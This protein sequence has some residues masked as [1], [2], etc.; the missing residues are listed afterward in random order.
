LISEETLNIVIDLP[1][2][3]TD[4]IVN[5][6]DFGASTARSFCNQQVF[7]LAI[8]HCKAVGASRLLILKGVYFF[9]SNPLEDAFLTFDGLNDITVDGCGSELIFGYPKMF[10]KVTNCNRV[11][12]KHLIPGWN[13]EIASLASVGVFTS[14]EDDGAYFD[15]KFP[16]YAAIPKQ[17]PVHIFGPFDSVCYSPGTSGGIEYRPYKNNH[18]QLSEQAETDAEM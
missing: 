16:A 5:I 13:W 3:Q 12:I 1:Q 18:P 15:M 7:Q 6:V 10:M 2:A 17:W 11:H 8:H 4:T 9:Y 14:V